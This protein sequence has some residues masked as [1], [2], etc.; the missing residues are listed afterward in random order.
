MA[1]SDIV[2]AIKDLNRCLSNQNTQILELLQELVVDA[3]NETDVEVVCLSN[4][5][6]ET[7]ITGWEVFNTNV[8]PPTSTIWL[9]GV[10]VTGN[11]EIVPCNNI[12]YDYEKETIC[13]D[14]SNWTKWFVWDKTGDGQPNL[15]SILWLDEN[16]SV[17]STPDISLINNS[18]CINCNPTVSD[19]F[20]NDL[21]TLL[22]G[23]SFVIT[24]PD[25]CRILISTSVGSFTL[26][27]KETYYSTTDFECPITID[28]IDIISGLCNLDQIHIISN[29]SK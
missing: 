13:V 20:A 29:K 14:G 7:I 11:Y 2:Q 27:E 16:D 15:V 18:N 25:C 9:N 8:N 19:A 4:D 26:R 21:S 3:Q 6:G 23:T 5:G 24:K 10:D 1:S 22:P 12:K 28:N 17:V